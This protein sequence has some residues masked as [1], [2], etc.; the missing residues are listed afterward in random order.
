[1]SKRLAPF[2]KPSLLHICGNITNRLHLLPHTGLDMISTDSKVAMRDAR[3]ILDGKMGLAGNVHPVFVLEELSPQEVA[4]HTRQCLSEAPNAGFMLLPGCDLSA[5][6]PEKNVAAFVRTGH[7]WVAREN[8][9][10][11]QF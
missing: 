3:E 2:K 8:Q 6:T 5:G 1:M 9:G 7:E 10:R 11:N 4:E